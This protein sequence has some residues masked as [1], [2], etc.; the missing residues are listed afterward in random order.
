FAASQRRRNP[1]AH[2]R[3]SAGGQ[4][5][6]QLCTSS[7]TVARMGGEEP[8][9]YS[10]PRLVAAAA[11]RAGCGP[12]A[13]SRGR[14]P[15]CFCGAGRPSRPLAAPSSPC[16]AEAVGPGGRRLQR[17]LYAA[18]AGA[19]L[20]PHQAGRR[21]PSCLGCLGGVQESEARRAP[22]HAPRPPAKDVEV[23]KGDGVLAQ[24][25]LRERKKARPS[26]ARG[27]A[28]PTAAAVPGLGSLAPVRLAAATCQSPATGGARL[29][30]PGR[31]RRGARL[32][33]RSLRH[34][35]ATTPRGRPGCI[36]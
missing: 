14:R 29:L 31:P 12:L 6:A 8:V 9:D 28:A 5:S 10:P 32:A 33:R 15:G 7:G 11:R 35:A 2:R 19:L 22:A 21:H 30:Q 34:Q 27:G 4:A 1:P 17:R 23:G 26:S 20:R 13:L 18:S 16:R 24:V 25:R 3:G 36:A